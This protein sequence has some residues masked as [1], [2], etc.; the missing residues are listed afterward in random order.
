MLDELALRRCPGW[1]EGPKL[2]LGDGQAWHLPS[3]DE[4]RGSREFAAHFTPYSGSQNLPQR[5]IAVKLLLRALLAHNYQLDEHALGVLVPTEKGGVLDLGNLGS[6]L[7]GVLDVLHKLVL[8]PAGRAHL[9]RMDGEAA[10][11]PPD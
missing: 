10:G 3:A 1:T 2:T 8:D 9:S 5:L 11:Q 7:E 6:T 4:C